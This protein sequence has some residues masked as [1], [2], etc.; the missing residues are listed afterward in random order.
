MTVIYITENNSECYAA[1]L[2]NKG[3]I[4]VQ[5]FKAGS[6]DENIIYTVNPMET[7]LGKRESCA[8]TAL[9]GILIRSVLTVILCYLK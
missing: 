3:W 4:K 8:M 5:K 2:E 9:S 7:F 1:T 6:L